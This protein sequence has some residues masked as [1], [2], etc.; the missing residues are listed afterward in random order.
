MVRLKRPKKQKKFGLNLRLDETEFCFLH[1]VKDKRGCAISAYIRFL[2][3]RA[4][5]EFSRIRQDRD[6]G[7]EIFL[8]ENKLTETFRMYIT[9]SENEFLERI[10]LERGV[11]KNG[12]IRWLIR[13]RMKEY[14]SLKGELFEI[15]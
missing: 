12:F 8:K 14:E 9:E 6:D 15:V 5:Y 4:A 13:R 11:P 2:L 7:M 10:K 3:N 1:E